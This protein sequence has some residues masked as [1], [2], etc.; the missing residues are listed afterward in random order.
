M[1]KC[2]F[3]WKTFTTYSLNYV[4][5]S[6]ETPWK[7]LTTYVSKSPEKESRDWLKV[8]YYRTQSLA[9]GGSCTVR[10]T[11]E[12]TPGEANYKQDPHLTAHKETGCLIPR[13]ERWW[14]PSVPL[15]DLPFSYFLEAMIKSQGFPLRSIIFRWP[16]KLLSYPTSPFSHFLF[17]P[18]VHNL[19]FS[20][21]FKVISPQLGNNPCLLLPSFP[22]PGTQVPP[23]VLGAG[24]FPLSSAAQAVR[25]ICF[26]SPPVG[27]L[28]HDA[29]LFLFLP[30]PPIPKET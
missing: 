14:D 29:S 4:G 3:G 6:L 18:S 10:Y 16:S 15:A 30:H 17:C 23:E 24:T 5:N 7:R 1:F 13:E 28:L 8:R 9:K 20:T 12:S 19:L 2:I 21:T 27:W 25:L 22:S 11:K 26:V